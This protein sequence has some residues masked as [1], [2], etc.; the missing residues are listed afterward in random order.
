MSV[1]NQ[2]YYDDFSERYD[3]HR[4]HAYHRLVDQL[5]LEILAPLVRGRRVLD[6][7]T[8]TGL[9]LM[10]LAE[11][12]QRAVGVDLSRGMLRRAR[13]RALLVAQGDAS[14]L[15]LP[16]ASFDVACCFKA[17]PHLPEPERTLR[18]LGRVV[19][20]GG[21]VVVELYNPTSLRG[22]LRRR[23][24]RRSVS[25]TYHEGHVHTRYDTVADLT[26]MLPAGLEVDQ[27][28]GIRITTPAGRLLS[29]P[30]LG[31]WLDGLE[32]LAT[33][34]PGLWRVAGFVVVILRRTTAPIPAAHRD[35]PHRARMDE[36]HDE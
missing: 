34:L 22:L 16:D 19:R 26:A 1:D 13:Q 2:D 20:Q 25:D 36:T 31:S 7:A 11:L 3:A 33:R 35:T 5:E 21:H 23:G 27:V 24:P 32:R 12:A 15:P 28:R 18:E 14:A 8:G 9:T 30:V 6:V 4:G 17:F 29:V 10:G